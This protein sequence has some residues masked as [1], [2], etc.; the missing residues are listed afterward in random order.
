MEKPACDLQKDKLYATCWLSDFFIIT[1][2]WTG[3]KNSRK[4]IVLLVN[5]FTVKERWR[6]SCVGVWMLQPCWTGNKQWASELLIERIHCAITFL[7]CMHVYVCA[8]TNEQSKDVENV[9]TTHVRCSINVENVLMAPLKYHR[10]QKRMPRWIRLLHAVSFEPI[11]NS[12][13]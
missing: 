10:K 4:C 5:V 9:C 12:V 13:S 2:C 1:L 8:K 3:T 11:H 7:Q 6:V